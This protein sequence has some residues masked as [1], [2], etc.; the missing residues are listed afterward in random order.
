MSG[1]T[2]KPQVGKLPARREFD[3]LPL[4]DLLWRLRVAEKA[5][6]YYANPANWKADDWDVKAVHV[7]YGRAGTRAM[8]A[9]RRIRR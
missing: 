6:T 7:E 2:R 5:L 9:L 8:K 4:T 1:A 3:S